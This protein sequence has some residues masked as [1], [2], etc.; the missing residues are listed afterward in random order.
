MPLSRP[1]AEDLQEPQRNSFQN[2]SSH[3]G[4]RHR[5]RQYPGW[6]FMSLQATKILCR[7][8]LKLWLRSLNTFRENAFGRR[9]LFRCAAIGLALCLA[10]SGSAVDPTRFVSQY[11]HDS[12]GAERGLAGQSITAIA[13]TSDGYL[14][15][16]TDKGLLR[17][18]GLNFR[19]FERALP[20]PILIGP[21][22]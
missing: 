15:I 1:F 5:V 9:L 20:D 21:V 7:S 8:R 13:Q 18:D 10:V 11:I 2:T 6:S 14:W 16:G 4:Y 22:R 19:Q 17:F 3:L 12:W